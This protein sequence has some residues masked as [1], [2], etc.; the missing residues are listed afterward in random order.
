[1]NLFDLISQSQNGRA[2]D[3]LAEQFGIERTQAE[4]AVKHLAPA[5][6]AGLNRNTNDA[7]GLADLL[8]VLKN[9]NHQRYFDDGD[10]LGR[11]ETVTEG[12]GI[13]GHLFGSKQVSR[14]VADHASAQTGIGSAILRKMLPVIATMVMGALAKKMMGGGSREI[15]DSVLNKSARRSGSILGNLAGKMLSSNLTKGALCF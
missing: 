12:N 3:N 8:G 10:T 5:L 14:R 1:M 9:G 4:A 7:R 15:A 2:I 11:D 6:G 13:L